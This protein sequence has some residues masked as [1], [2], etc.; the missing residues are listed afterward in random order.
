MS[1]ASVQVIVL[2]GGEAQRFGSPKQLARVNGVP[3]LRLV[4]DRALALAGAQVSVILG[5]HAAAVAP[6]LGR[7]AVN[8]VVNRNWQEGLS[9][10]I[11]AGVASVPGNVPG[12]LLLLADQVG[13]SSYDLQRLADA[14]RRNP[15]A[16]V[17]AQYGGGYGVPALFP[18][19]QFPRLAALRG[20]QGARVLLR[21]G[22]LRIVGVPMPGAAQDIDT[23]EDLASFVAAAA[24]E[25]DERETGRTWEGARL[26]LP[27]GQTNFE[28]EP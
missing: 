17:A 23:P 15:Q 26:E 21:G 2:A 1:D 20:E 14:W 12:A 24:V 19:S 28:L 5:A 27:E 18:R 11:R 8:V 7:L 4:L 3:M 22:G 10:S 6:A 9:A 16:I 13:V 25:A